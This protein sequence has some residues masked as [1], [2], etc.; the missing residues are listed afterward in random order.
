MNYFSAIPELFGPAAKNLK[1]IGRAGIGVDNI[2][3]LAASAKGVVVMNTPFGNSITTAEHTIAMM[4][5]LARNIA[6]ASVSTHAGKWEKAKFV[7]VELSGKTLGIIGCGNIGSI[8]ADRAIG[9]K[10][11]VAA[12]DPFLSPERATKIGVDKVELDDLFARSDVI[13]LHTPLTDA[14]RGI[15]D[16]RAI[17]KMKNG[18]H[19]INC[20]RGG[21]I[22][23]GDL[24]IAIES[25]KVSGAAL[26]VFSKEPAT[27]NAW[28]GNPPVKTSTGFAFLK[29]I[30]AMFSVNSL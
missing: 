29:L 11:K 17:K 7:G 13:S 6:A 19:I 16:H 30:L 22:D 1:I 9:L 2:D 12:Y 15:I 18:V 27:E 5:A 25:G 23:E 14:T 24:K 26:D 4:F 20:A 3:I 10:M 8:V 21:L 28:Q